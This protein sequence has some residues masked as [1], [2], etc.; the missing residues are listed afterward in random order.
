MSRYKYE[1]DFKDFEKGDCYECPLSYTEYDDHYEEWND[2]CVLRKS[3]NTH[4]QK[5]EC[6]NRLGQ[7]L[8]NKFCC[9]N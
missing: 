6:D 8:R 7:N 1:F 2:H 4:N 5:P 9:A 3:G